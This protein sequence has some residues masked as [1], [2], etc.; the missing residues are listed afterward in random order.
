MAKT[1]INLNQTILLFNKAV[2]DQDPELLQTIFEAV[3]K[4]FGSLL[5]ND[6]AHIVED[7]DGWIELYAEVCNRVGLIKEGKSWA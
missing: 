2:E 3:D 1:T 6:N 5:E 4:R 7:F